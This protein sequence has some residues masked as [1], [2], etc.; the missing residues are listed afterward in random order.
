[1]IMQ[2]QTKSHRFW[3]RTRRPETVVSLYRMVSG[4]VQVLVSQENVCVA[5]AH[6]SLRCSLAV[7]F[8]EYFLLQYRAYIARIHDL[9]G[10]SARWV[11]SMHSA[12]STWIETEC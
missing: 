4:R 8:A 2:T 9:F 3:K 6:S 1:M 7:A 12:C 10:S 11:C 5:V